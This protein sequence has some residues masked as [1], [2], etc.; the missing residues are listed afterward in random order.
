MSIALNLLYRPHCRNPFITTMNLPTIGHCEYDWPTL[1]WAESSLD[2]G[3]KGM[4]LFE[5]DPSN[6]GYYRLTGENLEN[7]CNYNARPF[8]YNGD[9]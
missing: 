2:N 7:G 4:Q 8:V 6:P 5:I 1:T 3:P 9:R